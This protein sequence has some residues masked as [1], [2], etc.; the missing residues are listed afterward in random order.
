MANKAIENTDDNKFFDIN[1]LDFAIKMSMKPSLLDF[2]SAFMHKQALLY[3]HETHYWLFN[4][5][6][7]NDY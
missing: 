3:C 4:L 7:N 2:I 5:S 1:M 6:N